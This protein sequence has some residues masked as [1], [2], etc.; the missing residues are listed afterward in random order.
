MERTPTLT[1]NIPAVFEGRAFA[2]QVVL[3]RAKIQGTSAKLAK[4][5]ELCVLQ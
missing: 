1:L 2:Y 4:M 3:D 5:H